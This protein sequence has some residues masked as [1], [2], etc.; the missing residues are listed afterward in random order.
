MSLLQKLRSPKGFTLVELIIV[1]MIIGILA[2]TL[3]PKVMGAP[4][5]AR[6]AG[7][8]AD[9]NSLMLALQQSYSDNNEFPGVNGTYE[10][11]NATAGTG[12]GMVTDGY[13]LASNFP[14]EQ[15]ANATI[16]TC[17]GEYLYKP[18]TK[19]GIDKNAFIL[20]ADVEN[21]GEANALPACATGANDTAALVDVC[22]AAGPGTGENAIYVKV[23]GV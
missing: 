19:N 22:I 8:I 17:V 16:G 9:L 15:S 1:I 3:L 7:R 10:C 6:D 18:I 5:R 23:G 13:L 21:D 11:L 12:L 20:A 4:A 14:L 2:A